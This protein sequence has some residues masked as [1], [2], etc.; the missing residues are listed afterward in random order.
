MQEFAGLFTRGLESQV[1]EMEPVSASRAEFIVLFH[2][3]PYVN[4]W[5][6]QGRAPAELRRYAI[7]AMEGDHALTD[8][9]P[10]LRLRGADRAGSR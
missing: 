5:R 2:Y 7:S 1:Y 10:G 6:Q 4:C 9:F 3:C 8:A